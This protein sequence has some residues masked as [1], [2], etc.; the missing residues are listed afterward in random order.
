MLMISSV[1][2]ASIYK[3]ALLGRLSVL[4][5]NYGDMIPAVWAEV[6]MSIGSLCACAITYRPLLT[7]IARCVHPKSNSRH[8]IEAGASIGHVPRRQGG[9]Q[10]VFTAMLARMSTGTGIESRK[11]SFAVHNQDADPQDK[12]ILEKTISEESSESSSRNRSFRGHGTAGNSQDEDPEKSSSDAHFVKK[13]DDHALKDIAT[14]TV[15]QVTDQG[16]I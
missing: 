9:G 10:G 12:V 4:D 13:R 15:V 2:F 11:A 7:S 6:E 5:G 14:V 3:L 8:D 1:S 16:D